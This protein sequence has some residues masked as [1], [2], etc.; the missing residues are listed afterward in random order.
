MKHSWPVWRY[1]TDIY[2][3]SLRQA[4]KTSDQSIP[5]PRFEVG[6]SERKAEMLRHSEWNNPSSLFTSMLEYFHIRDHNIDT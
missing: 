5:W 1:Y 6:T 2:P 3:N 4:T